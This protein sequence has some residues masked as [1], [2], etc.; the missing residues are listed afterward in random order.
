MPFAIHYKSESVTELISEQSEDKCWCCTDDNAL[1]TTTLFH[2]QRENLKVEES[3]MRFF[4]F[5][6]NIDDTCRNEV[7]DTVLGS[8]E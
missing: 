2:D 5:S 6:K 4:K 1:S 3:R 7:L 8:H